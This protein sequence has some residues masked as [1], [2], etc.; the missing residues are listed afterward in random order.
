[1][2]HLTAPV[3]H[4]T[5]EPAVPALYSLRALLRLRPQRTLAPVLPLAPHFPPRC[6]LLSSFLLC[7]VC[8]S[9][10]IIPSFLLL[11]F[12]LQPMIWTSATW[13][14]RGR[15]SIMQRRAALRCAVSCCLVFMLCPCYACFAPAVRMLRMP[16]TILPCLTCCAHRS[17]AASLPPTLDNSSPTR[18]HRPSLTPKN[19]G[20]LHYGPVPR[21]P[22]LPA[23]GGPPRRRPARRARRAPEP[24][25]EVCGGASRPRQRRQDGH[26]HAGRAVRPGER[27][28]ARRGAVSGGA[29]SA[30]LC[31]AVSLQP[32]QR[33]LCSWAVARAC[34]AALPPAH[35]S[36][37]LLPPS[38]AA[39]TPR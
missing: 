12:L 33:L 30:P 21:R 2:E 20:P 23:Q 35:P 19:A 13:R 31:A 22:C 34:L 38:H 15:P 8:Q 26:I 16:C 10:L 29:F 11:S 37:P 24:R 18:P 3:K 6:L 7:D 28:H 27:R 4:D 14:P 36:L 9:S 25:A 32:A 1:M 5:S 39:A 17:S